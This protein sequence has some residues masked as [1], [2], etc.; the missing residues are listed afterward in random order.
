[1][2][3]LG[4]IRRPDDT[5]EWYDGGATIEWNAWN[6]SYPTSSYAYI[7]AHHKGYWEDSTT[8]SYYYICET[9]ITGNNSYNTFIM[10]II[11]EYCVQFDMTNHITLGRHH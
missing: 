3:W 8:S 6:P 7:R 5:W 2:F 9:T 11:C 1:M 4:G 10:L